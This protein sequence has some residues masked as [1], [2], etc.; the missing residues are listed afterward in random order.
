[1][2]ALACFPLLFPG[3]LLAEIKFPSSV[4]AIPADAGMALLCSS[5]PY[6]CP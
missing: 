2:A 3:K 5:M 4:P 1:M 6:A